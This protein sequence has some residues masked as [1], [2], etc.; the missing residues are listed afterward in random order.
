RGAGPRLS[1]GPG[2]DRRRTG[3]PGRGTRRSRRDPR[4]SGAA[5]QTLYEQLDGV[6]EACARGRLADLTI[7]AGQWYH[8][9][10]LR[11]E[12]VVAFA[13]RLTGP[14]L[15]ALRGMLQREAYPPPRAVGLTA[16]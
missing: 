12:E 16:A 6:F 11:P 1:R 14:A 8:D 13:A 4:E 5:E 3:G 10:M 9:L 15:D 7:Q 2:K